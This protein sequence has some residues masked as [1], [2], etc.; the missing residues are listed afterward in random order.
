ME[1]EMP[2]WMALQMGVSAVQAKKLSYDPFVF[3]C[4][5]LGAWLAGNLVGGMEFIRSAHPGY[6]VGANVVVASEHRGRGV[7]S[8]LYRERGRFL[9]EKGID[10]VVTSISI[11]NG[12][13]L[14]FALN[15]N[16]ARGV[17]YLRDCY[18]E[19]DDKLWV[20]SKLKIEGKAFDEA[21][22][23]SD[24]KGGAQENFVLVAPKEEFLNSQARQRLE[25]L[26]NGG[27]CCVIGLVR[28]EHSGCRDNLLVLGPKREGGEN[29]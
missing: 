7:G 28:P 11:W 23:G 5:V 15:K 16:G 14:N 20:E 24:Y 22:A 1:K 2:F 29:E 10:T 17:R 3:H 25:N 13:S 26:V 9:L 27:G 12:P 8:L 21:G 4:W 19:G 6:A 18:V